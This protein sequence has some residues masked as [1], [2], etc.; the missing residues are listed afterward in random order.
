M[1]VPVLIIYK[2]SQTLQKNSLFFLSVQCF[3]SF[4][5]K[6]I[7]N[8]LSAKI[9][10]YTASSWTDDSR[11]A[12][13]SRWCT[14]VNV[15]HIA[16]INP[17]D[18]VLLVTIPCCYCLRISCYWSSLFWSRSHDEELS[19]PTASILFSFPICSRPHRLVRNSL[20]ELLSSWAKSV[21]PNLI[22]ILVLLH[23]NKICVIK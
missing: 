13:I 5:S 15:T 3:Y 16:V 11:M 19:D 7:K 8:S 4:F 12:S 21:I 20:C 1:C 14:S 23:Q 22:I 9:A 2:F 6:A 10:L 17:F 18:C